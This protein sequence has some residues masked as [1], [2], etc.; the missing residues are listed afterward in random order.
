MTLWNIICIIHANDWLIKLICFIWFNCVVVSYS[1]MWYDMIEYYIF[2]CWV[3][4]LQIRVCAWTC[5][6]VHTVNRIR[7]EICVN[8][9]LTI[10]SNM[11]F[12]KFFVWNWR[13][14]F[15]MYCVVVY[16]RK[17]NSLPF[18]FFSFVV[19]KRRWAVWNCCFF[20]VFFLS[21]SI[22]FVVVFVEPVY[23]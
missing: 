21:F 6:K 19:I 12:I 23:F 16:A 14:V 4:A 3:G 20:V 1:Y 5:Y 17:T 15:S 8:I 18:T 13:R 2:R 22:I 10:K 7:V 11:P 9:K